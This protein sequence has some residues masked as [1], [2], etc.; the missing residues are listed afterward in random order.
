MDCAIAARSKGLRTRRRLG[1]LAV[2]LVIAPVIRFGFASAGRP[3]TGR[4]SRLGRGGRLRT[5]RVVEMREE[6]GHDGISKWFVLFGF[7][8]SRGRGEMQSLGGPLVLI[9]PWWRWAVPE[10][11]KDLPTA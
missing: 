10:F 4:F 2:V 3:F 1:C 5:E 11:P 9:G 6:T 8:P 7:G